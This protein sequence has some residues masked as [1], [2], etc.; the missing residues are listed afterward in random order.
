MTTAT[1]LYGSPTA[2]TITL[3]G[4]AT[5][6]TLLVGRESTAVDNKDVDD[7]VDALVG[8]KVTVGTTPTGATQIQIWAYGSYDDTEYTGSASGS[9]AALTPPSK[10]TLKLL[11]VIPHSGSVSNIVYKWGPTSV[12]NA[13]G[14]AMPVQWGIWIT[15]N[16]GVNLNATGAN[17]EVVYIPVKYESA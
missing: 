1:P 14:G 9:D 13:F 6:A 2:L 8:G 10:E 17:Q 7:A 12:A 11:Q 4:L 3:A 16:T 15:H 5:S